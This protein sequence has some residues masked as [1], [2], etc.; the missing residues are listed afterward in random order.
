[1]S[2]LCNGDVDRPLRI[3]VMD[4]DKNGK[5][6]QIGQVDTSVRALL[7]SNGHALHIIDPVRKA[8]KGAKYLNE[9]TLHATYTYVEQNPTFADVSM[10]CILLLNY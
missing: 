4:W 1:M 5:H 6:E 9:G 7:D 3:E 8:K 10:A 2:L